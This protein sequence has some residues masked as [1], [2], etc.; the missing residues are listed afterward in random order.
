MEQWFPLRAL[1]PSNGG[2]IMTST[3]IRNGVRWLRMTFARNLTRAA[4]LLGILLIPSYRVYDAEN[5]VYDLFVKLRFLEGQKKL[6]AESLYS[7]QPLKTADRDIVLV[8]IDDEARRL[9]VCRWLVNKEPT[10]RFYLARLMRELTTFKPRPAV[11]GVDFQLDHPVSDPTEDEALARAIDEAIKSGIRLVLGTVLI[12]TD[13]ITRPLLPLDIFL[14]NESV[15]LG[16]TNFFESSTDKVI[17]RASISVPLANEDARRLYSERGL[18]SQIPFLQGADLDGQPHH[19]SFAAALL[20]ASKDET[21]L[22]DLM[23]RLGEQR[24][25]I[26]FP[27][28]SPLLFRLYSSAQLLNGSVPKGGFEG[29]VVILGSSY[30][31]S[32][33]RVLTPLSTLIAPRTGIWGI[34][35]V[36]SSDLPGAI[37]NA[38]ALHTLR[39]LTRDRPMFP[40]PWILV[41]VAFAVGSFQVWLGVRRYSFLAVPESV[42]LLP[43]LY[44]FV[45]LWLFESGHGFLPV[46]R[47][48]AAFIL[49]FASVHYV[50]RGVGHSRKKDEQ[51]EKQ[52]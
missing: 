18:E 31:G 36:V 49:A 16:F 17:R 32:L 35:P 50:L 43:I 39:Q 48:A 19:L 33:D 15:E 13:G 1:L 21:K 46:V 22:G 40:S 42:L 41:F 26:D 47:P 29:A 4:V 9:D 27:A 44:L 2:L 23:H 25:W 3:L 38:Y 37:V 30:E 8:L 5:N 6:K 24:F 52:R 7:T 34:N 51:E 10:S 11:V 28:P 12:E 45:C 14:H 20:K